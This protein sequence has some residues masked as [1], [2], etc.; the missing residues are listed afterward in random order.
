M[1]NGRDV[2][3]I[4]PPQ[5]NP[6]GTSTPDC[7]ATTGGYLWGVRPKYPYTLVHE[8]LTASF[9]LNVQIYNTSTH[10]H[11]NFP[12]FRPLPLSLDTVLTRLRRMVLKINFRRL[13][14]NKSPEEE[15]KGY[16]WHFNSLKS[17]QDPQNGVLMA[18]FGGYTALNVLKTMRLK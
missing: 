2:D 9:G 3:A 14:K 5:F 11:L 17:Y 15:I 6:F 16:N 13:V 18:F 12:S 10:Y 7:Q 1:G 8:A 4:S